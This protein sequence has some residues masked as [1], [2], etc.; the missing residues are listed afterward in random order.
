MK[1]RIYS[2]APSNSG[3]SLIDIMVGM[4]IGL[5]AILVIMQVLSVYEKQKQRTTGNAD[6][7]TSGSVALYSI[8]R[9]AGFAGFG[10]PLFDTRNTPLHC[11]PSITVDHDANPATPNIDIFPIS[12]VDGGNAPGASDTI[13]I[14][15]AP[16]QTGGLPVTVTSILNAGVPAPL[17]PIVRVDN[18]LTCSNNDIVVIING[19]VCGA[20]SVNSLTSTNEITLNSFPASLMQGSSLA[21]VGAWT[22]SAYAV[23][24]NQLERNGVAIV[25]NIVNVQAQYG[26][27]N[28]A[29]SNQ[30]AQWVDA[31]GGTWAAPTIANRNRI[32]AIRLAIVARNGL[33]E[34]TNV[35]AGCSSLTTAAPTGLCAWEGSAGSPAPAID[36]S[37]TP[38]WQ[39]YRYRVYETIIPL[40]NMIWSQNT[41]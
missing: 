21:C 27:S 31:S 24:N 28:V 38:N 10:L 26:V 15:Y 22:Q 29:S 4:V 33:P 41:L 13:Q 40:R 14:R 16:N 32:K 3:F 30:I 12:I 17:Q 8:G 7:Q 6:A 2:N 35:T 5:L 18:N 1:K 37:N 11:D 36:L 9:E 20:T 23:N 34:K 19:T 25:A 39:R